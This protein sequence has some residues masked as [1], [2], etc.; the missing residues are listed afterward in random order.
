MRTTKKKIWAYLLT[1]AMVVTMLSGVSV[2]AKADDVTSYDL[3]IGD[4]EVTSDN[5]SGTGWSYDPDT[6]TLTLDNYQ[7]E[8]I[9]HKSENTGVICS[10]NKLN[11]VLRG[12]SSIK[13]T[14]SSGSWN[15]GIYVS[16]G[17]LTISGSGTLNV[18][19]GTGFTSHGISVYSGDLTISD[20]TINANGQEANGSSGIFSGGSVII[21]SGNV[22]ATA[23]TSNAGTSRGIECNGSFIMNGGS[24]TA[25]AGEASNSSYGI[26]AGKK[27]EFNKGKQEL[28]GE[29]WAYYINATKHSDG[30]TYSDYVLPEL[31]ASDFTF[32]APSDLIYD[33]TEKTATIEKNTGTCGA[34]TVKYYNA[35]G[36]EV[37]PIE[38]G[39]YT[40]KIDVAGNEDYRQ[41]ENLT[42][43]EWKFEIILKTYTF[44]MKVPDGASH[45]SASGELTQTVSD[46]IANIKLV[47][48]DDHYFSK[49]DIQAFNNNY[50]KSGI[51]ISEVSDT[52]EIEIGGTP[53][54]DVA[55]SIT[56]SNKKTQSTPNATFTAEG[57]DSG[58][59]ADVNS[60]M[61]YSIDGGNTWNDITENVVTL[62]G[63]HDINDIRVKVP[64]TKN[65]YDSDVQIIKVTKAETPT[66]LST[67]EC[68]S[69]ADAD[70]KI[71]GLLSDKNY[72]Y[73]LSSE[74]TWKDA[75][76]TSIRNLLAGTY[77]IRVKADGTT[78]AS[79]NTSVEIKV[80]STYPTVE[81]SCDSNIWKEF[82]NTITFGHFF[83]EPKT[84]TITASDN[85]TKELTIEYFLSDKNLTEEEIKSGNINWI[86]YVGKFTL[87]AKSKQYIYAKATDKAGNTTIVNSDGIVIYTDSVETDSITFNRLQTEDV[88]TDVT[89]NGN[90]VSKI[91][92]GDTEV[93]AEDISKAVEIKN[94]TLV[95]KADYLNTIKPGTYTVT[96]SYDPM[97]EKYVGN[98]KNDAPK[99]SV[100]TLTINR[101]KGDLTVD[102]NAL[103]KTYDGA[104]VA[105]PVI[106]TKNDTADG[107]V[108]YEYKQRYA[109]DSTY[110]STAPKDAGEYTVKV[111]V[112]ADYTY[113]EAV[114]YAD[115]T[116]SKKVVDI[117]WSDADFTFN[118][119]AQ[120]PTAAVADKDICKGDTADVAVSVSDGGIDA[121]EHKAQAYIENSNY[122]IST[123]DQE[124][125][126][127]T[128]K[129]K[130][131]T[132][133]ANDKVK[134]VGD[135]N[136][137][138]D[139][140][141]EGLV[142]GFT[143]L[144][145]IGTRV[146]VG[147]S[148]GV[149]KIFVEEIST[150]VNPNY[151]ITMVPGTLTIVDHT[152]AD[153][154]YTWSDDNTK[155][156]ATRKCTVCGKNDTE[157]AESKAEVTQEKTC[158]LPKLT[159]YT[160]AF[161]NENGTDFA[162]QIKE[163]VQTAEATGHKWDNGVQSKAP[164]YTEEG[165]ML[166]TCEICGETKTEVIEKLKL[167]EYDILEG[168]DGTHVLKVDGAYT[169]RVNCALEYFVAV[170]LDGKTVDSADYTVAS[171][172]TIVTFTK[173]FMDSLSVGE[174]EVKFIF[175]NGTAKAAIKVVEKTQEN[176]PATVDKAAT[177]PAT[178]QKKAAK[179]GD[180]NP[181]M[182][183]LFL[184]MFGGAG[185][186]TYGMKRKKTRF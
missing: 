132:L 61:Q 84:V 100:I 46:K 20:A 152:Y 1:L 170:Q 56:V 148:A 31:T 121:G 106:G 9:G 135:K 117:T 96:V 101:I 173:E 178:Q 163:N 137:R 104:A 94:D 105:D 138:F 146:E 174:H 130:K 109:D 127:Y 107:K 3:W 89:V 41:A 108:K 10:Q 113:T 62:N 151:D 149:Y 131:I 35:N 82:I 185:V 125:F 91:M 51:S 115:F 122:V 172:S 128:I 54:R 32:A 2:T 177:T 40:V 141:A 26:Q 112:A 42:S 83:K 136:P 81:I 139:Y 153:T 11:L 140:T 184:I 166:Y 133:T 34:I 36:E 134:H 22:T 27:I 29:T 45:V 103:N 71:L 119:K 23:N 182:W 58:R 86:D 120:K 44:T 87:P 183:V 155:C 70:G 12:S 21:N 123:T 144:V 38:A 98:D 28:A 30:K 92:I 90:T 60:T 145:N 72:E 97:G 93:K 143:D 16:S 175:T 66:D 116:I 169:V 17:N 160:V 33:G 186:V 171:G 63:L 8:G 49:D 164:T 4:Q 65:S 110:T 52:Q 67:E 77:Q 179:S 64:G 181:A 74:T 162:D 37:R 25:T 76:G 118:G 19:G 43:D 95:F 161:K 48:D 176:K 154:T 114:A 165:E 75:T 7:Y 129:P 167:N 50:S 15:C 68:S 55:A 88:K 102:A 85:K 57:T 53:N 99:D 111:T 168:A 180:E 6:S 69:A 18:T 142:E 59:L 80:D 158:T 24:V 159:K 157:T 79:D 14:S 73:K 156:T 78:F 150:G 147:E 13:N 5:L 39:V 47:A 126:T 124:T